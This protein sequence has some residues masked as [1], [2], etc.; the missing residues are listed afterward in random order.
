M[1][2]RK[3]R[4]GIRAYHKKWSAEHPERVKQYGKK[5]RVKA[6]ALDPVKLTARTAW[7]TA[8]ERATDKGWAFTITREW[9]EEK[10]SAGRCELT[11]LPF[12]FSG[13]ARTAYSASVDRVNAAQGYTKENCRVIL[14]AL[15]K[16]FDNWGEEVF[17]HI[18]TAYLERSWLRQ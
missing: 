11:G 10:L 7:Y 9:L 17:G 12:D 1:A 5:Q 13:G 14:W 8:R 3:D 2:A 16:A 4:A 15:N 6:R 18:W